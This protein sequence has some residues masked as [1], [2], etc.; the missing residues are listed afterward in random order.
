MLQDPRTIKDLKYVPRSLVT[1]ICL[2]LIYAPIS[3]GHR[4][5]CPLHS[6]RRTAHNVSNPHSNCYRAGCIL[7]VEMGLYEEI[8][9]SFTPRASTKATHW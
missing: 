7:R 4:L 5:L 9:R 3:L 1:W 2:S 6:Y 8:A